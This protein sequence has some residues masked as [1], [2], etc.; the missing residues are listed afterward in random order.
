V[1]LH[2]ARQLRD[3]RVRPARRLRLRDARDHGLP[4][5]RGRARRRDGPRDR[6]RLRATRRRAGDAPAGGRHR[7]HGRHR[8]RRRAR[9]RRHQRRE[10]RRRPTLAE[11]GRGLHRVVQPRPGVSG[12]RARRR[13]P[14]AQPLR[15]AEHGRRDSG[16]QEPG[17]VR[18]RHREGRGEGGPVG[19][20]L[21]FVTSRERQAAGRHQ[22]G[23]REVQEPDELRRRR[24]R[25][26]PAS[27]RGND[28]R[29]RYRP[30]ARAR[31]QLLS[32]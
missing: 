4:R 7:R 30:G 11:R 18:D 25:P 9:G 16:A 31:P 2:G 19:L 17:A 1:D 10:Q 27:D 6:P 21:A 13:V 8:A 26:L 23:R 20:E 32:R 29:R 3:Q 15:P 14:G 22:S 12:R 28:V 5:Q 24:A